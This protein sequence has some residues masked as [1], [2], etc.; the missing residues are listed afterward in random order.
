MSRGR[1]TASILLESQTHIFGA[2][3]GDG[4]DGGH[5]QGVMEEAAL[6]RGL[7]GARK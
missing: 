7:Q 3:G 4:M 6:Q 2:A 1:G 5:V